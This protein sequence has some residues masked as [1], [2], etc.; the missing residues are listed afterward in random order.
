MSV[1]LQQVVWRHTVAGDVRFDTTIRVGALVRLVVRCIG[2][3]IVSLGLYWPFA[4]VALARYRITNFRVS[5]TTLIEAAAAGDDAVSR[6]AAGYEAAQ[7]FGLDI[8][9]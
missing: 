3:T 1:R 8:G 5:G 4:A 7:D 2:L 6:S 9:L